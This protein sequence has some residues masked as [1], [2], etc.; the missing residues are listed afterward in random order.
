MKA[1]KINVLIFYL[2][3]ICKEVPND[4]DEERRMNNDLFK[5]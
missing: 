1:Y 4:D 3:F 2:N 5:C